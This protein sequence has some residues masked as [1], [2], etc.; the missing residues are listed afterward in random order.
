M[1]NKKNS[2]PLNS[3]IFGLMTGVTVVILSALLLATDKFMGGLQYLSYLIM[4]AGICVGTLNFQGQTKR[5]IHYI[6]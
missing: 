1:E 3:L 4:I 5:W 6:W 2:M